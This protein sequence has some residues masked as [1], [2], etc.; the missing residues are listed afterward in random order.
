MRSRR[1]W[2]ETIVASAGRSSRAVTISDQPFLFVIPAEPRQRRGPESITTG[3]G[4]GFR[5][6]GLRPRPGMTSQNLRGLVSA[7]GDSGSA[8]HH[9]RAALRPGHVPRGPR[10]FL[11]AVLGHAGAVGGDLVVTPGVLDRFAH[12]R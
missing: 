2:R 12:L 7:P 5:A 1:V 9:C 6:R 4:Y 3:S 10:L 11:L 8:A